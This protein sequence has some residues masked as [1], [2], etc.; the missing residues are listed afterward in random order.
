MTRYT[1]PFS[2]SLIWLILISFH[3]HALTNPFQGVP[4][5]ISDNLSTGAEGRQV[6]VIS[7]R[8]FKP[9]ED[10][11]LM[12]GLQPRYRMFTFVT[13]M[14]KD[15]ALVKPVSGIAEAMLGLSHRLDFLVYV[16]GHG[17]TFDQLLQRGFEISERFGINV[18]LFD[19][20]TDYLALRKTAQNA[21]EV[22]GNFLQAMRELDL[23]RQQYFSNASFSVIFHS[24]GNHILRNIVDRK[25]GTFMPANLFSNIVINAAA[26]RQSNH[27]TWIEKVSFARRIYITINDEDRPLQGA[28]LLRMAK[29]LGSGFNGKPASNAYY[30]DFSEIAS[31]EHNL[32]LGRSAIEMENSQIFRFYDE[33]FHGKPVDLIIE[34]GFRQKNNTM[35]YIATSAAQQ[36]GL[37]TH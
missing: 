10:Y 3:A 14:D 4:F 23:V 26:V 30:I 24:M 36:A 28:R 32:F 13:A 8:F 9:A 33:A 21:D 6:V 31:I 17:K 37:L 18:V 20:P 25:L 12:R 11:A 1:I 27:A 5:V 15:T 16:D 34:P 22:T 2:I 7:N 29:Q 35:V 19:W